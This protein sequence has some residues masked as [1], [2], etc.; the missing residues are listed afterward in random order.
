MIRSVCIISREYPPETAY[1]GIARVVEMTARALVAEGVATHVISLDPTG[2]SRRIL[3]DGVAVYRLGP[4]GGAPAGCPEVAQSLWSAVVAAFYTQLDAQVGFDVVM[5]P[6]YFAESL[7]VQP[8]PDTPLVV[9]L[10]AAQTLVLPHLSDERRHPGHAVAAQMELAA[11]R[12]A[13]ALIAPTLLVA[14]LTEQATG[15]P[16]TVLAPPVEADRMAAHE[17]RGPHE[18]E[19]VFVGRLEVRKEPS[20]ALHTLAELVRRGVDARL[21]LVGRDTPSGPY[22]GSYRRTVL[23]PLMAR[24]GLG[25]DRVRFVAEL[26]LDGVARHLAVADAAVLPSRLENLHT[27]AIEALAAGLP[28]V[29]GARSGLVD[30]VSEDEGL[31]GIPTDDAGAFA[32]RAADVL[33]DAAWRRRAGGRGAAAV[34]EVFDPRRTVRAHLEFFDSLRPGPTPAPGTL[35]LRP[36]LGVIVLA[37]NALAYTK[38]CVASLQRHTTVPMRLVVVDNASTDETAAWL[39]GEAA[40]DRR[41]VP[42]ISPVNRGVSGGRNLGLDHLAGDEDWVVFLDNDTEVLADWWRPY[43]AALES[44]PDAGICGE[45]GVDARWGPEGRELVPVAGEGPQRCDIAVGFCMVMRPA[46][47]A[48]IGRFDENL[49]LFWHDDDDYALRAARIG[50]R[51]LRASCR[52]VLHFEHR[53]SATVE[54]LWEAPGRPA[55]LSVENQRY[56]AAKRAQ[57][58]PTP[59]SPFLVLADVHEVLGAPGILETFGRAFTAEDDAA[60]VVY[61]PGLDPVAFESDL[62]RAAA[63]AGFD[64]ETGPK[65]IALAPAETSTEAERQ[66]GDQVHAALGAAAPTGPLAHL[67]WIRA[68]EPE[69]LRSLAA[70]AWRARPTVDAGRPG[71]V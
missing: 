7:K 48:R 54:G 6:D 38:R 63:S 56:V 61:G 39:E 15:V 22:E 46:A 14:E 16:A 26:G 28:V 42:V 11:I 44:D 65:V 4:G 52:R 33:T 34:R 60:L 17:H 50:E 53:S 37:H 59:D 45:D 66:V 19:L 3:Q 2:Q 70:R 21:T 49:G 68:G 29:C 24:L 23:F 9:Q 13:D 30:W 55:A 67:A 41:L 8:R 51:V 18:L 12:R 64:L 27:A 20:L 10:H 32:R 47:I 57:Q 36:R 71:E 43:V 5:A 1:G 58:A 35:A 31:V 40:R 69:A 62:R 25:F